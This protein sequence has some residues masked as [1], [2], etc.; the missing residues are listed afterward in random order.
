MSSEVPAAKRR[1]AEKTFDWKLVLSTPQTFKTLLAI[2]EPTVSNVPFQVCKDDDSKSGAP[3]SG[4]RL[5]AMN[6][7]KICMVKAA[8]QCEVVVSDTLRN[9]WFCVDTDLLKTLLRDVQA[10]HVIELIRYTASD[11]VTIKTYNKS[12][13]SNWSVSTIQLVEDEGNATELD[14]FNLTFDHVVE[15]ELAQLKSI[16]NIVNSIN[17]SVIEFRVDE[18]AEKTLEKHHFFTIAAEGEGAS[19]QKVHHSVTVRE[20]NENLIKVDTN[21]QVS[22]EDT[23]L[24]DVVNRFTGKFPTVYL[25]GVLKSMERQTIQLFL[26]RDLPLVLSYSLGNDLSYIKVVLAPREGDA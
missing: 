1:R 6:N 17:S 26:S 20:E 16:C 25:N 14:M 15:I 13:T 7:S 23:D 5:D 22:P 10:T 19:I 2:I 21:S 4:L 3:F 8:Y 9:E 18:P 11:V 12:D 24:D